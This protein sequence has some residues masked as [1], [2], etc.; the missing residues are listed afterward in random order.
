MKAWVYVEGPSDVLALTG[1]WKGWRERLR[2]VRNGIEVVHLVDKA[3]FF[4]KLGSR[5]AEKL[6]G[7]TSDL[8]IGLP[9]LYPN[10]PFASGPNR[11]ADLAELQA[12]QKRLVEEG[13][14]KRNDVSAGSLPSLL[15]RFYPTALKHDLEM[16][17]LAATG[18]LRGALRTHERLGHW[19]IPVEDQNQDRPPKFIVEELFR[20][21][22]GR[23]YRDTRDAPSVLRGVADMRGLVY[24]DHDQ[25]NCP[26][27]KTLLDWLGERLGVPAYA[28]GTT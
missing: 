10:K 23:A 13:L 24:A 3:R 14:R 1:L 6:V 12:L 18:E 26:V 2:A 15:S 16:L 5:A 28:Q 20:T 4:Q 17:L 9:D 21:K 25:L 27:F 22:A 7:S 8:V 19:R 11:H